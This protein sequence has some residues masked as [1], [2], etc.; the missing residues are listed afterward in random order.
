MLE[1]TN[2]DTNNTIDNNT[3][4]LADFFVY[5]WW[6]GEDYSHTMEVPYRNHYFEIILELDP[7]GVLNADQFEFPSGDSRLFFLSP[8]R[9][10]SCTEAP[11]INPG[12]GFT[13]LFK[14]EFIH[15]SVC[16][17][18]LFQDFPYFNAQHAPG[19]TLTVEER[20]EFF[21][22]FARI[23]QEYDERSIYRREIIRNYLQILLL[24]GR[25]LYEQ[26]LPVAT[27][28]S[29]EQELYNAF[30]LL[31]QAHYL[32]SDT[33]ADYAARLNISPKYLSQAVRN[34]CGQSVL[35]ILYNAR[36]HHA[37]SLMRQTDLS[38]PQIAH[39]LNFE[40]EDSFAAFFRRHTGESPSQFRNG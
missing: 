28:F 3:G 15:A 31:V 29:L 32:E 5:S 17:S 1:T 7:G 40:N 18:G 36:L 30:M 2:T 21:E 26:Q 35:Q 24:K 39:T 12:N 38:I 20:D 25:K 19:I 16:Q 33:V 11:S 13:I 37:K 9:P 22:L 10:V 14:P 23:R 8:F 6:G 34:V 4:G 27:N